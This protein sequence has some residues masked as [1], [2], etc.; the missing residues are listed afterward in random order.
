M[1]LLPASPQRCRA[2]GRV[3]VSGVRVYLLPSSLCR[4]QLPSGLC[5]QGVWGVGECGVGDPYWVGVVSTQGEEHVA[6]YYGVQSLMDAHV[7]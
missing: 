5:A 4:R 6:D 2:E 1:V 7:L 3:G